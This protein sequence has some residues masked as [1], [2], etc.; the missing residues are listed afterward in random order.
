[1]AETT[2]PRQTSIR[3]CASHGMLA[4]VAEALT[5]ES[6]LHLSIA[7]WHREVALYSYVW[8]PDNDER[9]VLRVRDEHLPGEALTSY[10]GW[11]WYESNGS[12]V[13]TGRADTT[14]GAHELVEMFKVYLQG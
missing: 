7:S 10:V 6:A 1:M 12:I 13:A 14:S 11:A 2:V 5:G 4:G 9:F 8:A 3:V